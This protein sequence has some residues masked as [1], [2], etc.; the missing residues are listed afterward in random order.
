MEHGRGIRQEPQSSAIPTPRFNQG[1]ATLNP[2]PIK[3][4]WRTLLS[5]WY[6][7]LP[8]ISGLGNASWKI[9]CLIGISKLESQLQD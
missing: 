9:P 7:G 1:V 2:L 4:Y 8:E 5:Q 6:D 3:S